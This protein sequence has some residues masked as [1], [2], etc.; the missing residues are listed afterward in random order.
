MVNRWRAFQFFL[1]RRGEAERRNGLSIVPAG[2]P[3]SAVGY[4]STCLGKA[5]WIKHDTRGDIPRRRED[6]SYPALV[7][8]LAEGKNVDTKAQ[9][10]FV[11]GLDKLQRAAARKAPKVKPAKVVSVRLQAGRVLEVVGLPRGYTFTIEEVA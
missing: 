2:D 4:W 8:T 7:F 1:E 10:R 6:L 9:E 5:V 11:K 3:D